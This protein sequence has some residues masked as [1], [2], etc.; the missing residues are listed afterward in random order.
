MSGCWTGC[1]GRAGAQDRGFYS[2]LWLV[3][4]LGERAR[5]AEVRIEVVSNDLF[6]VTGREAVHP[7]RATVIGPVRVTPHEFEHVSGTSQLVAGFPS[8]SSSHS[9]ASSESLTVREML[10]RSIVAA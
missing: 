4:A 7:E 3:Q 10:T 1:A 5:D 9:K 6:E 8:G 2:L